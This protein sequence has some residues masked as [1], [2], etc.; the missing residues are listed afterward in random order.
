MNL[1]NGSK[2]TQGLQVTTCQ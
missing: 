2:Q 1:L